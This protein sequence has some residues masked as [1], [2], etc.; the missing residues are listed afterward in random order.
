MTAVS[1]QI[2]AFVADYGLDLEVYDY[3]VWRYYPAWIDWYRSNQSQIGQDAAG[4]DGD[5]TAGA[6]GGTA[7]AAGSAAEESGQDARAGM[8]VLLS[9]AGL[10]TGLVLHM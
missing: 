4:E 3:W 5:A 7:A 1:V 8:F 2:R 9:K 10:Y 6:E